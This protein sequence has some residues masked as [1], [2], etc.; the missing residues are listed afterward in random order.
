[1]VKN[2]AKRDRDSDHRESD[3]SESEE[4]ER[5]GGRHNEKPSDRFTRAHG[6]D[7]EPRGR[8]DSSQYNITN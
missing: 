3:N 1:M 7:N 4:G 5:R 6:L 8:A 2:S